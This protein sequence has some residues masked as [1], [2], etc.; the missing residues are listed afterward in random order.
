MG[1]TSCVAADDT[2]TNGDPH[3]PPY[4]N[5]PLLYATV[6]LGQTFTHPGYCDYIGQSSKVNCGNNEWSPGGDDSSQKCTCRALCTA[7]CTKKK[8]KRIN[9]QGNPTQCCTRQVVG[10]AEGQTCDPIYVNGYKTADCNTYMSTYCQQGTNGSNFFLPTC[11]TWYQK[12]PQAGTPVLLN[13]CNNPAN[14]TNAVCGCVVAANNVLNLLKQAGS[15]AT[16]SAETS[17]PVECV[18]TMCAN[19]AKALKTYQQS[20]TN[21]NVVNCNMDIQGLQAIIQQSGSF[22]ANFVQ[23]CG[24]Q[25]INTSTTQNTTNVSTSTTATT[26]LTS[27][28]GIMIEVT[29]GIIIIIA[30]IILITRS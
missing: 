1:G 16:G 7:G 12:Q 10:L 18:S 3:K 15:N 30:L 24:S 19:N 26:F 28:T 22:N 17:V 21:C 27:T 6:P 25:L 13:V 11:Q 20:Q 5:N 23:Q 4:T 14:A 9:Y 8:C 29:V 2:G